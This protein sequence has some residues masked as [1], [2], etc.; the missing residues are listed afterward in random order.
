MSEGKSIRWIVIASM[1]FVAYIGWGLLAGSYA[2]DAHADGVVAGRREVAGLTLLAS[3]IYS[4]IA[5][6]LMEL[7]NFFRV[8]SWHFSNRLWLLVLIVLAE[9]GVAGGG[10]GLKKLEENLSQPRRRR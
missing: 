9:V 4:F 1:L 3:A 2:G 6:S 10:Y 5:T 8:I 7:P